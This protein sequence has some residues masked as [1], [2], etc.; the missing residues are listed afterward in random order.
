MKLIATP[1][2]LLLT[3]FSFGVVKA[4]QIQM[5][6]ASP[7]ATISQKIGLT[8]VKLEYSRPSVK[9]RKI[10]GT[11]VPYGEVWRT[12]ANASTKITFSTPVSVEGHDVPAGTYALYAIPN[13]KE[14]TFVLSENLELWGAIGYTPDNDV[15]RFTVP[16]QKSKEYYETMELSFNDMTDTGATLNLHWEKTGVGFRIETEVDQVVMSQ[17]QEMVIDTQSDNPGLLYQAA[18]YYYNNDKDM[19]Q[20]HEWIKTSVEADP[21]YWTVHLKA[22]IEDKLGLTQEAIQSAEMSKQ[23][24]DEAKNMDYVNLNDRLIKALQ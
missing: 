23:L 5:P 16:S 18:S 2:L 20:A 17:I 15:L 14:W 11:L 8:D 10:F 19:E 21:K 1:F 24:A 7:A 22:K 3:L 4:Q 9:D 6:Q 13:K 12:G